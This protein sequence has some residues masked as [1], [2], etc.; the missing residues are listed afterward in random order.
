LPDFGY[1]FLPG[2]FSHIASLKN[3]KTFDRYYNPAVR[4]DK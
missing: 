1:R 3:E 2:G 4:I